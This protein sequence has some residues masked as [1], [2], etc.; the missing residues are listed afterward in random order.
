MND[1]VLRILA[2]LVPLVALTISGYYR[3][4]A[5]RESGE[6]VSLRQEERPIFVGLR[7]GGLM[8]WLSPIL[9]AINPA[10][11]SWSAMGLPTW[12]R[13]TGA[14]GAIGVLALFRWMFMA[15]GPGI[16]PTVATRTR[17]QLVTSGPYRWIRHPLYTFG[18]IFFLSMAALMDNWAVAV[19]SLGVLALLVRR[20]DSEEQH[21]I[22]KFG[23]EYR[24]YM[25][26]TG[27]FL[28]RIG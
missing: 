25:R 19:L 21:L 27:R 11:L 24:D 1:L 22:G 2:A 3:S 18:T 7:L 9:F 16:T 13:W 28:P 5:D 8:I 12:A 17:H 23:D 6:R 4:K 20:T 15:I 10:W 14:L 26:R